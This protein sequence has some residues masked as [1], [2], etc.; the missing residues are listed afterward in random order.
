MG[1]FRRNRWHSGRDLNR[2]P[3]EHKPEA[4][5][6]SL[7]HD[8]ATGTETERARDANTV[9]SD[10]FIQVTPHLRPPGGYTNMSF[11]FKCYVLCTLSKVR[12]R[13]R[14]TNKSVVEIAK[15]TSILHLSIYLWLY[16]PLLDL[17]RFCSS[18]ILNIV[19]RTS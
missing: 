6:F 5:K 7:G 17:A 1:N 9:L 8:C 14:P 15:H 12:L 4:I 18:L 2:L 10:D 11:I 3:P 19:G 13:I 16:I